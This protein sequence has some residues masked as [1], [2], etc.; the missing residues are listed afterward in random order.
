MAD[1]TDISTL[2]SLIK[3]TIDSVR[4][5]EDAAEDSESGRF[6]TVFE[7]FAQERRRVVS[8]LQEE[9]RR[10]GG[11]P[12]DD[13]SFLGTA[14]RTFMNLKQSVMSRDN[15]AIVNE[16]ERGEDYIKEKYQAA[17]ADEALSAE[18]RMVVQ[19][20]YGSIREGH[21]RASALKHSMSNEV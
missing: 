7:Q 20:V 9:V 6:A 19:Q 10:L 15:K 1:D 21:D 2:N 4:G 17:L 13:S 18:T 16:V 5:F 3:T 14:H 8:T 12:E 11:T